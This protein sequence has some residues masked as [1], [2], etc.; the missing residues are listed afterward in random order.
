MKITLLFCLVEAVLRY[1]D[2][3]LT[4]NSPLNGLS[5]IT[6]LT[7]PLRPRASHQLCKG[8][9]GGGVD[10]D[11]GHLLSHAGTCLHSSLSSQAPPFG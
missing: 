9:C 5:S 3:C 1:G 10:W 4:L 11:E 7:C 6:L 8:T 2:D